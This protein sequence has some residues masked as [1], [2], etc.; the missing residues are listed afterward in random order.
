MERVRT[1]IQTNTYIHINTKGK[2]KS[3]VDEVKLENNNNNKNGTQGRLVAF[4]VRADMRAKALWTPGKQQAEVKSRAKALRQG[5]LS[6]LLERCARPELSKQEG[7]EQKM[8]PGHQE[9]IY[10]FI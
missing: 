3:G 10:F 2:I 5:I 6:A 1:I 9:D 4:Q 8:W 7:K